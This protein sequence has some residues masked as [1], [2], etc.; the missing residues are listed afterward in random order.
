MLRVAIVEDE[1][2]SRAAIAARCRREADFSVVGE[3]ETADD[4]AREA[5]WRRVDVLVVDLEL[6]GIMSGIGLIRRAIAAN[7]SMLPIVH[8]VYDARESLFAA[9]HA[10]AVGYVHKGEPLDSLISGIRDAV[11]GRAPISP[12]VARYFVE[13][14][15]AE[16]PSAAVRPLTER[17]REL[18]ASLADGLTYAE[19]A[20]RMAISRHTVHTHVK[21]IYD[22]LHAHGRD[23]AVRTA[24]ITG[25]LDPSPE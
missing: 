15:R 8:T 25:V 13:A 12:A 3:W 23:Q 14:F 7:R 21:T 5:D 10:G 9:I 4:A 19:V 11:E 22:K 18:L 16:V 6:P 20:A 24:K 2:G 1:P 17:E